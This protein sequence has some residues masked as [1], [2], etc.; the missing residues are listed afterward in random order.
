MSD[1]SQPTPP[2]R[3]LVTNRLSPFY[4]WIGSARRELHTDRDGVL[5]LRLGLEFETIRD[6]IWFDE[7]ELEIYL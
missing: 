2:K 7:K 1:Q 5:I 6:L 4:G 3:R